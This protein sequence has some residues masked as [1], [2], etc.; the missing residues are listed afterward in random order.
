MMAKAYAA[1]EADLNQVLL[2]RRQ[3]VEATLAARLAQADARES[4]LRLLLD[5][6]RLWDLDE[7]NSQL[8]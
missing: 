2:A 4:H 5:A 1:G 7:D 6:H 3:A 8:H